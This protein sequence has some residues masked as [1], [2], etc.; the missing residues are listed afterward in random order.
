MGWRSMRVLCTRVEVSATSRM[1]PHRKLARPPADAGHMQSDGTPLAIDQLAGSEEPHRGGG[2]WLTGVARRSVLDGVSDCCQ[3]RGKY[4]SG[5]EVEA[6]RG[7]VGLR[8]SER[9][10]VI[11]VERLSR[12]PT[13]VSEFWRVRGIRPKHR[14]AESAV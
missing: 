12:T 13:V 11:E 9:G 6:I 3:Q 2:G 1:T 14:P 10:K 5:N 7:V 4:G 8:S